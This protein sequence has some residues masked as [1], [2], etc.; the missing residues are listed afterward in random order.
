MFEKENIN[1]SSQL[2]YLYMLE[3]NIRFQKGFLPLLLPP[4]QRRM[5]R[6]CRIGKGYSKEM[7]FACHG[8]TQFERQTFDT[9]H[10]VKSIVCPG[11]SHLTW[12]VWHK[13]GGNLCDWAFSL[14]PISLRWV[15]WDLGG[16]SQI[17]R[18]DA[19]A[20]CLVIADKCSVSNVSVLLLLLCMQQCT[21]P[22][23]TS[24]VRG[25]HTMRTI[26]RRAEDDFSF[27]LALHRHHRNTVEGYPTP[28]GR[29]T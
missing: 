12:E 3:V 26:G 8:W 5:I 22:K 15:W 17:V 29:L 23:R 9:T 7:N 25:E 1:I 13:E 24:S 19:V 11:I 10:Y 6:S 16:R 28:H 20:I 2:F 27:L 18:D 21:N 14:Q 4:E